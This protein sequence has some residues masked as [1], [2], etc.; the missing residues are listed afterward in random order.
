MGRP[1]KREKGIYFRV[2]ASKR[3]WWYFRIY[4]AKREI[5]G[6]PFA[7]KQEARSAREGLAS[8]YRR[9]RVDPDGGWQTIADV[10]ARHVALRATRKDQRSQHRFSTWWLARCHADGLVRVKELSPHFLRTVR[11]ELAA[12]VATRTAKPEAHRAGA[13][14]NR[15]FRWL[16]AALESVKTTQRQLFDSW[17]WEP[18]SK[19]R[20]R[21]LSVEEESRLAAALGPP[22]DKWMRL[23]LLTGLRQTEQFS[24]EWKNVDLERQMLCL[25]NTKSNSTQFIHLSMEAVEILR[26]FNSW[27]TSR[28][29]FPSLN[30]ATR[31]NTAN[32]YHRTWLRAI[33]AAKI[34]HLR[35][36]DLRHCA[37]SRLAESGANAS[38]LA[39]FLRHSNLGLV[40]RYAHLS[41]PHLKAA[42]EL[43]SCFGQNRGQ[44]PD[45]TGNKPETH[46]ANGGRT[47]AQKTAKVTV[48]QGD[49]NGA[50]DPD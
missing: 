35:W 10:F 29:V 41:Q 22:F 48:Q 47:Q 11:D 23:A 6:G 16:H 49:L 1:A 46:E 20:V 44:T 3:V 33:R 2:D 24:L 4:L 43:V 9:G 28:W 45:Q 34:E 40:K 26:G 15:Y 27:S 8:D 30:P 42:A 39:E 31:L 36:H 37:A 50:G 17:R 19:G 18:E 5:R 14:I 13:T 32:F 7:G 12:P 38:T 21:N 25:P